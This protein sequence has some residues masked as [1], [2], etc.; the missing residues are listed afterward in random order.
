MVVRVG[1]GEALGVRVLGVRLGVRV[2][3]VRLLLRLGAVVFRLGVGVT[4]GRTGVR[5][6]VYDGL[7]GLLGGAAEESS[8]TIGASALV[9]LPVPV[10]RRTNHPTPA[11]RTRADSE[12]RSG[13]ATPWGRG[14]LWFV[15]VCSLAQVGACQR[16][17]GPHFT[18]L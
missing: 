7:P 11:S 15:M 16:G 5:R 13:P 12:A 1:D 17:D 14:R 10:S 6:G 4:V 2:L 8:A 9:T 18:N 3:G